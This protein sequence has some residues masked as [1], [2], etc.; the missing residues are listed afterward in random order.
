MPRDVFTPDGARAVTAVAPAKINL[1]LGVGDARPDG[2]HDLLTVYRAVDM[3]ERVTVS[4]AG[5][6]AGSGDDD[7]I[8]VTGPGAPQ[9]P[10]DRTNL[11]ARAVDLL[12][13]EAGS[14]A[15]IA[16]RI[17]KG[18]PV[19]GGMAGGSADAAAALVATDRLLGLGLGRAAL[20]ERAARLGSDVPFCVRGGTALGTGRGEKLATLLHARAEQ[21]VVVALA[22]GGLSTPR[23]FAEL[24]R[25]RAERSVPRAG[26]VEPLVEAL[27]GDDPAAVAALLANDLEPAALSL[28]PALRKT[29]RTGQEAGALH[30]M[31]S[32][33]GPTCLFF[34][35]DRD[36]AIAVAAEISESGVAREVRV[37]RG[38]VG[39]AHIISDDPSGV[40]GPGVDSTGK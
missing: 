9:V 37:T 22:A 40:T 35:S 6:A 39:G 12:R 15:R 21:H 34:C 2:F 17:H 18:V 16:I 11:A 14:D 3:W 7:E 26:G 28:R 10:T 32:G 33:S 25:L 20:E 30:G 8:T 29:L 19:A 5:G 23:V 13:E 31:V 27:A 4:F 38:P 36:H 1:H 24:D